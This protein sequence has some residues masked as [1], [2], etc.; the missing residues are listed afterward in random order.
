[1]KG[2]LLMS[3]FFGRPRRLMLA[4]DYLEWE[5][6]NLKGHEFS[7]LNKSE[8]VDFKH[9]VDSIVWYEFRVGWE[10][11]ITFKDKNKKELKIKF[12]S[13]FGSRKNNHQ[14]YR[15]VVSDI[16]RLYQS[17]IVNT[18]LD[19]FYQDKEVE[20][21]GITLKKEGVELRER[22]RFIPWDKVA[23]KE[24][25]RYFAI[26]HKDDSAIHSRVSY[27]EYGTEILWSA[28]RTILQE[29]SEQV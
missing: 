12:D 23:F 20:V 17:D 25:R 3:G 18:F 13:Y 19:S 27:N 10:F 9:R 6:G 4:E 15:D 7:K 14:K 21:Q 8:I 29:R 1:M 5:N 28:V 26:Y 16:W 11:W 2:Y 24:Y 22:D